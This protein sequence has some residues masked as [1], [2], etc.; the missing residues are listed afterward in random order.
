[1]TSSRS[2][3][4]RVVQVLAVSVTCMCVQGFGYVEFGTNSAL[5]KAVEL[6]DPELHGRKMTIMVSKPPSSGP[7]G[8]GAGILTAPPSCDSQRTLLRA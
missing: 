4:G 6:K 1:M 2:M 3:H 7:A 5:L 8:R